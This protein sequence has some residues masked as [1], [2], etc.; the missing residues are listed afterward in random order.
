MT[1]HQA[2]IFAICIELQ[3]SGEYITV[4][5]I[6]SRLQSI[7]KGTWSTIDAL[8]RYG[9]IEQD[10]SVNR[11][12]AR[13]YRLTDFGMK[14]YKNTT[15]KKL[16]KYVSEQVAT[17]IKRLFKGD[18][19]KTYYM[20]AKI[21]ESEPL[22]AA[23]LAELLNKKPKDITVQL[24]Q[25]VSSGFVSRESDSSANPYMLSVNQKMLDAYDVKLD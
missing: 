25:L 14:D 20:L 19:T 12:N 13:K 10:G 16:D 3:K 22:T 6:R 8:V 15:N 18:R 9:C 2:K 21:K 7:T 17:R 23:T 24:S 4:S 11:R 1:N 5:N